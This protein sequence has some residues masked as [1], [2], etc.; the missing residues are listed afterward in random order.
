METLQHLFP[1]ME[2]ALKHHHRFQRRMCYGYARLTS[3]LV[4]PV[5]AEQE[6]APLKLAEP[7]VRKVRVHAA[8]ND[9]IHLILLKHPS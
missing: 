8:D 5:H 4:I 9:Y 7:Q 2:A 6:L 1:Y 3:Q